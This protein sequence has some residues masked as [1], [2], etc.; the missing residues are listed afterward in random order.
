M[1]ADVTG[2]LIVGVSASWLDSVPLTALGLC[3]YGVGV[4]VWDVAMNVEGADVER[5]LGRTIMPRFHAGYSLGTVSGA[6]VGRASVAVGVPMAWHLTACAAVM[7]VVT[8]RGT[9]DFLPYARGVARTSTGRGR[10]WPPGWSR[11]RC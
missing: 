8:T 3:L 5:E 1:L 10:R 7:G 2:L 9:R 4:A 11:G 6:L